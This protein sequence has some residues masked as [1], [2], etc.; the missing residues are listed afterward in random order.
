MENFLQVVLFALSFDS[1]TFDTYHNFIKKK[2]SHQFLLSDT[3]SNS[4]KSPLKRGVTHQRSLISKAIEKLRNKST[5]KRVFCIFSF[6]S[7]SLVTLIMKIL[8]LSDGGFN[9]IALCEDEHDFE[10]KHI[11]E[12]LF[13]GASAV[14]M[15]ALE[16]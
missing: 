10:S 5:E 15:E 14:A 6:F 12:D 3:F 11:F 16:V 7:L 4:Q 13:D 8:M 9:G 2:N 1:N